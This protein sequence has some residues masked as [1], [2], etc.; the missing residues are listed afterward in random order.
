GF[1]IIEDLGDRAGHVQRPSIAAAAPPPPRNT[2]A[3]DRVGIPPWDSKSSSASRNSTSRFLASSTS[4]LVS[5]STIF[6]FAPS[7]AEQTAGSTSCNKKC[8][9]RRTSGT[10][11]SL[12]SCP[13]RCVIK[14]P[15]G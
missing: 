5:S 6:N 11:E 14:C 12:S 2:T 9:A 10:A 15:S 1:Q 8:S 7:R 3:E 13:L 4:L